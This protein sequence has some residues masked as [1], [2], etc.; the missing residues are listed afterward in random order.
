[1]LG[2]TEYCSVRFED[3]QFTNVDF[4]NGHLIECLFV[5]CSFTNCTATRAMF[6]ETELSPIAFFSGVTFPEYNHQDSSTDTKNQFKNDFRDDRL[7]LSRRLT[8]SNT[9]VGNSFYADEGIYQI[10]SIELE[11][12]IAA[13][14]LCRPLRSISLSVRVALGALNLFLSKGGTS[15]ARLVSF[16]L[17]LV[18]TSPFLLANFDIKYREE[19]ITLNITSISAFLGDY[20]FA[21]VVSF[22]LFMGF[23]FTNF[24]AET[25]LGTIA[26]VACGALGVTWLALL[27]PVLIRRIYK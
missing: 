22:S 19:C 9:E 24:D 8:R 12:N 11:Q 3:C 27:I 16:L 5:N 10:R 17:I 18:G 7:R 1:M 15:L 6:E 14:K 26:L 2:S 23:G 25:R 20:L 13:I 21:A 4:Q